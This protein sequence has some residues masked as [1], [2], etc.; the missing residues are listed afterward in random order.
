MPVIEAQRA[1]ILE[2]QDHRHISHVS[3]LPRPSQDVNVSAPL[4]C[5]GLEFNHQADG[6]PAAVFDLDALRPGPLADLGRVQPAPRPAAAAA[7]WLTG[8]AAD[9]AGS[10]HVPGQHIPQLLR[11]PGV[12]VD[13]ILGTVHPE[14]D[15]PLGGAAVE[16]ID[17]QGL[18]L[19]SHGR[20][21]PLTGRQRTSVC[22]LA[23][24]AQPAGTL[25]RSRSAP[26][27]VAEPGGLA[28]VRSAAARGTQ[29]FTLLARRGQAGHGWPRIL[30]C[31][32]PLVTYG[33]LYIK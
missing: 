5:S 19:L 11:M 16:I 23:G 26:V 25:N 22:S 31:T 32:T 15:R 24:Q 2:P 6:H 33:H 8:A 14:A 1:S 12:Q 10:I 13:L 27:G 7:G 30:A 29:T 28:E 4:A 3:E 20:L 17:E 21:D 18:Y 9:T